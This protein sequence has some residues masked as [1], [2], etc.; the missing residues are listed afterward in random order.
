MELGKQA[1]RGSFWILG[2]NYIVF[3]FNLLIQ[4][5]LARILFPEDFGKFALALSMSGLLFILG[6][7][8]FPLAL[9]QIRKAEFIEDT[10]YTLSLIL[11]TILFVVSAVAAV[12]ISKIGRP[13]IALIFF[14]VSI[15]NIIQLLGGVYRGILARNL[16]FKPISIVKSVSSLFSII[17]AL[18]LAIFGFG[19]W[20]LVGREIFFAVM[21]FFGFRYTSGWR[22]SWKIDNTITKKVFSFSSK[23]FVSSGLETALFKL[24]KL[25]VGTLIGVS[26][27]GYYERAQYLSNISV[28]SVTPALVTVGFPIYS[29]VQDDREK[30]AKVFYNSSFVI[31][32]AL[33]LL[34]ILIVLFPKEIITFLL[35]EKWNDSVPILRWLAFSIFLTPLFANAKHLLLGIGRSKE[36]VVVRALQLVITVPGILVGISVKGAEGAAVAL[37]FGIV[38]GTFTILRYSDRYVDIPFRKLFVAPIISM[39]LSTLVLKVILLWNLNVVSYASIFIITYLLLLYALEGEELKSQ[40]DIIIHYVR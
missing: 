8:S 9:I 26:T 37:I 6:G 33:F 15:S 27:L 34:S 24:D 19:V 5:A 22:Y 12:I 36:V 32:R 29:T 38:L 35:G 31:T 13:D 17:G 28:A 7:W 20:S 23:I 1:I 14:L 39:I 18:L 4:I 21:L 16:R 2:S 40:V 30:L 11:G 10:V 25:L 3:A